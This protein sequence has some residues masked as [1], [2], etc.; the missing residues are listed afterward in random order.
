MSVPSACPDDGCPVVTGLGA[1]SAIGIGSERMWRAVRRGA[2]GAR[3]V[4]AFDTTALRNHVGCEIEED[5]LGD[6]LPREWSDLPRATQLAAVAAREAIAHAGLAA[7][8]VDAMYVGTT[9]GD[10]PS[11]EWEIEA[12]VQSPAL[13]AVL[14]THLARRAADALGVG[15]P[16]VTIA[17]SCSAGNVALC[18]AVDLVRR[19]AASCVVAGQESWGT[20]GPRLEEG[21]VRSSSAGHSGS[22]GPLPLTH[23]LPR[24]SSPPRG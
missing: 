13:A 22:A 11:V 20:T 14:R 19:G 4:R 18:R 1:V 24:D 8:D 23:A 5:E 21:G 6:C 17:T 7:P 10:L 16:A 15:A 12:G 9:M 2:S 3:P